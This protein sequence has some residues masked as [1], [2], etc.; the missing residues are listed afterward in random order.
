MRIGRRKTKEGGGGE[1]RNF[2]FPFPQKRGE[3]ETGKGGGE[4]ALLGARREGE[5]GR[6][7]EDLHPRYPPYAVQ[8]KNGKKK[9]GREAY[10]HPSKLRKKEE[11]EEGGGDDLISSQSRTGEK[12][13]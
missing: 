13:G 4:S 12:K 5:K 6:G 2:L 7:K 11:K 10:L 9:K 8:Q 1:E 3:R